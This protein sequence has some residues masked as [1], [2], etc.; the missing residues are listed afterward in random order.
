MGRLLNNIATG[1][2]VVC[3]LTITG[4]VL[5]REFFVGEPELR[6]RR[7]E[8]WK[9]LH[10]R[11]GRWLGPKEACV[12]VAVF[13]DY[14]CQPCALASQAIDRVARKYEGQIGFVYFN[15]PLKSHLN[16][17]DA[18]LAAECAG[19]QGRY[20]E[21]HDVLFQN[22]PLIGKRPWIAFAELANIPDRGAFERCIQTRSLSALVDR[23]MTLASE[24]GIDGTPTIIVNGRMFN[25]APSVESLDRL[26]AGMLAPDGQK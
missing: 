18:A 5:R 25:G 23:D 20:K 26:I 16:A 4:I 17:Y 7:V 8:Q 3:A 1:V 21:F 14:E 15:L 11:G 10:S 22:Q 24:I 19:S 6:T 9:D 13:L 2:L 12:Q